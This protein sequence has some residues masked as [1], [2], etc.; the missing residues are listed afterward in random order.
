[1]PMPPPIG[2][3]E[4]PTPAAP[5]AAQ[6]WVLPARA[7]L[8]MR[9]APH[10]VGTPN[11]HRKGT[12][13]SLAAEAVW[14]PMRLIRRHVLDELVTLDGGCSAADLTARLQWRHPTLRVADHET[15]TATVIRCSG[16]PSA[17]TRRV[18]V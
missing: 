1:M 5:P 8:V 16:W 10:L 9:Q 7:W 15:V 11:P 13:N 12:T 18:T 14:P 17:R 6:R 3:G 2:N 4:P